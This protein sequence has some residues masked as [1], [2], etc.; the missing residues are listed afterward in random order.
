MTLQSQKAACVILGHDT[1]IFTLNALMVPSIA[2]CNRCG[3]KN[4]EILWSWDARSVKWVPIW[5]P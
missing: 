4:L 2:D 5:K 3:A 1:P